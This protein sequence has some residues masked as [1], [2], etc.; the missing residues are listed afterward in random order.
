MET[1]KKS[2][3]SQARAVR[4]LGNRWP[5][6]I[7]QVVG[8]D[9]G[10]VGQHIIV[11]QLPV[12]CNVRPDMLNPAFQSFK[13]I[14]IKFGVHSGSRFFKLMMNQSVDVKKKQ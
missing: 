12:V 2:R 7:N 8:D 13:D 14:H 11:V 9:E 3:G 1:E 4:E 6:C 5:H 10:T